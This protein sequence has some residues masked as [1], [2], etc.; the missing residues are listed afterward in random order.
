[1]IN[2]PQLILAD[3]PTGN[4]DSKTGG[5][6]MALFKE[7]HCEGITIVLVT[8][9]PNIAAHAQRVVRFLDGKIVRDER[10]ANAEASC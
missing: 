6:I 3:E 2:R 10:T 5:E 1:M 8:H 4:L 7:L 9:D